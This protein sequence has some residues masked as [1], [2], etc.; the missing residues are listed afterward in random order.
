LRIDSG[1]ASIGMTIDGQVNGRGASNANPEL[2]GAE[3][4]GI[5]HF[6]TKLL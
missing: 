3:G 6:V 5:L 1:W 2:I 4:A